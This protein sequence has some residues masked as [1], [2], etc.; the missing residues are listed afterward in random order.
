MSSDEYWKVGVA[1]IEYDELD[2]S[3]SNLTDLR[4][5]LMEIADKVEAGVYSEAS[6]NYF[7]N[8]H[9]QQTITIGQVRTITHHDGIRSTHWDEAKVHIPDQDQ[10][11][12]TYRAFIDDAQIWLDTYSGDDPNEVEEVIV[13][14]GDNRSEGDTTKFFKIPQKS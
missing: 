1:E 11:I 5:K 13:F 8:N 12:D 9:L 3:D 14:V 2:S 6:I 10:F 4:L 7:A